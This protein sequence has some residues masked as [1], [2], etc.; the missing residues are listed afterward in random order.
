MSNAQ[1][2]RVTHQAE[3]A[4]SGQYALYSEEESLFDFDLRAVL[5][6]IRRNMLWI[7]SIVVGMVL[8]GLLV[9]LLIV[10]KYKA[11]ARVLVENE[12][13]QILEGSD[14]T[15]SANVWDSDR[16]LKTQVEM[17]ESRTLA[18]TVVRNNKLA[19]D[20]DF[21]SDNGSE[22]PGPDDVEKEGGDPANALAALRLRSA[23]DLLQSNL[24]VSLPTES[25]VIEI[26]YFSTSPDMSARI[27]NSYANA[28]IE[29]N[30]N[31]KYDTSL[32]ARK[33]LEQQLEQARI[34]LTNS[35]HELNG[36][37]RAAGLIRV[38]GDEAQ[39]SAGGTLS[40]TNDAL[41][42]LSGAANQATA[43]RIAAEKRWNAV[44]KS[45]LLSIPQVLQNSAIQEMLGQKADLEGKLAD[46]RATHQEAY[47]AVLA[48]KAQV[49]AIES[50]IQAVGNS[51]RNSIK[52]DYEAAK[53]KE[54]ALSGQVG[55]LRGN[56]LAEQDRSVQYNILKRVAETNRSLYDALLQRYNE[57]NATA[58]SAANN[59]S[60]IDIAMVPSKPS[61]PKL[62]LNLVIAFLLGAALAGLVVFL[63]EHFDDR[64]RE[65]DDVE[66]KLGLPLLGLVP[67]FDPENPK[68]AVTEAKSSASEAYQSLV[69]TLLYSSSTGL[70]KSL[71]ITSASPSEGKTTT[72]FA[73]ASKLAQLGKSVVLVDADLRRPTLHRRV[74]NETASGLTDVIVGQSTIDEVLLP[75]GIENLSFITA[76]PMP[77]EPALLLGGERLGEIFAELRQRFDVLIVDSAP[78]LGLSDAIGL[79]SQVDGVLMVVDSKAFK[80]GAVKASLRRLQLVHAKMLGVVLTKFDPKGGSSNYSYYGYNYYNYGTSSAETE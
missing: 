48:L 2:D 32:H 44:A 46:E 72:S 7:A 21:F 4:A 29:A 73:I 27:A 15:P 18:E 66:R 77:P 54:A 26:N 79:T 13:A 39:K 8:L 78:M 45:P 43:D 22:I 65:P 25:R 23:A 58:G 80:R 71:L 70:P 40:I 37:S 10:P 51:I 60:M 76:L 49:D 42:Q 59:V 1:V 14:L 41:I 74:P 68:E 9:T 52:L 20:A 38:E 55:T 53:A 35:E 61:S 12:S 75:S 6:I 33:F 63:R 57:L 17:I 47:P 11:T 3:K 28:Y 56:A 24:A 5:A 67:V 34:R 50:R 64:I 36:Y 69:T 31:R 62:G 19:D 30:L 16:F